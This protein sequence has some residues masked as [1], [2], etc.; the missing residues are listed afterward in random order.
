MILASGS[1]EKKK[2]GSGSDLNSKN[3]YLYFRYVGI[4]FDLI[5]H[6]FKLKF[7][8]ILLYILFHENNFIYPLLRVGSGSGSGEKIPHWNH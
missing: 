1:A 8:L 5:N 7:K 4:K 3:I 6:N 2:S